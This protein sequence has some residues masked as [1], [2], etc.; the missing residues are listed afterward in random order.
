MRNDV[1]PIQ[2]SKFPIP[3]Y[4]KFGPLLGCQEAG[5]G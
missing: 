4:K 1:L 5:M 3:N 2:N